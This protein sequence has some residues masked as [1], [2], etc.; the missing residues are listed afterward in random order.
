MTRASTLPDD[1]E[2]LKAMLLAQEALLC[3][4][5][6]QV[7][8][9]QETVDS[10]KAALASRAAEVEHLK[11]LNAKLRRMRRRRRSRCDPEDDAHRAAGV[12]AQTT[13]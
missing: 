7:A 2:A 3:E 5:N 1:I 4:R 10:Q 11:L 8:T 13:T 6:A 12:A 9:L